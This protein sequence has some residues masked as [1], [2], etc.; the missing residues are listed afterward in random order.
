MERRKTV[1]AGASADRELG[2]TSGGY[3]DSF[4]GPDGK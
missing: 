3:H 4:K 1:H 2:F